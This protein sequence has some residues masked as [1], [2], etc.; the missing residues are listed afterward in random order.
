MARLR[1][2]AAQL[3]FGFARTGAGG[4]VARWGFAHAVRWLPVEKLDES[5][6][7]I[8]F[9]HPKPSYPIHVLIVPKR[10]I[11]G[12]AALGPDDTPLLLEV[13]HAAQ[14]CAAKVHLGTP[15][16]RLVVNG[17][18]YQDVRQLHFHLISE[19]KDQRCRSEAP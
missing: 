1:S 11:A 16:Y 2:V 8:A 17:G 4:F 3:A 12:L 10:A 5:D 9:Y 19:D 7:V 18:A 6:L 15:G 13:V 14:R